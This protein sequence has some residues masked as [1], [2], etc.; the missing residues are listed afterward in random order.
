[1]LDY[2]KIKW[3]ENES[4]LRKVIA[5][6]KDH[7]NWAYEDLVKL[8]INE[9]LNPGMQPKYIY[10]QSF[11]EDKGCW[12]DE[13]DI[14]DNG[15]YQGTL[16]F[17]IHGNAYQ[18]DASE[19]LMTYAD[20]GSCCCCDTLQGIQSESNYESDSPSEEQINDY[21]ALCKDLVTNMVHPFNLRGVEYKEAEI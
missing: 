10:S 9:I 21:M 14:I 19:Y 7:N 3:M 2:C 4:R 15:D 1:M 20:Y 6:S 8:V 5:E 17:V 12:D 16:I 18:P 13:I 11:N